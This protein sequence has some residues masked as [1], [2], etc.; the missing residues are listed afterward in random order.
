MSL[1]KWTIRFP[2]L[3]SFAFLHSSSLLPHCFISLYS[4][5][6]KIQV[7]FTLMAMVNDRVGGFL[8]WLRVG[9]GE[10]WDGHD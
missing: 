1:Q 4:S 9:E 8:R 7:F 5:Y 10:W 2:S 6:H 3:M